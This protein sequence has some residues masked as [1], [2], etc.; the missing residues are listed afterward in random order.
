MALYLIPQTEAAAYLDTTPNPNDRPLRRAP[1][2]HLG[3]GLLR[4][5]RR[6]EKNDFAYAEGEPLVRACVGQLLGMQGS[7]DF[8]RGELEWD[9][10]RGSKLYLLRH[11][12]ND[13]LLRELAKVYVQDAIVRFE[14]RVRLR[15]VVCTSERGPTGELNA[16]VLRLRYD[17]LASNTATNRVVLDDIRQSVTINLAQAA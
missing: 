15:A 7:S 3:R 5:F 11:Q 16:L 8:S 13:A 1:F 6:D 2:A 4:P 10:E 14:P 9:P 12:N 17:L